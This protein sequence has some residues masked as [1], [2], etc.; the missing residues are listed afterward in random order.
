[1]VCFRD[2]V[3]QTA[4]L[5]LLNDPR[6]RRPIELENQALLKCRYD[7]KPIFKRY[8]GAALVLD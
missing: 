1:M 4:R 8:P 6:P 7:T 5:Y 2:T 3:K